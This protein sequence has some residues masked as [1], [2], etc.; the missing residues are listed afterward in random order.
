MNILPSDPHLR[1]C[2]RFLGEK[3]HNWIAASQ[4]LRTP[5]AAEVSKERQRCPGQGDGDGEGEVCDQEKLGGR[6]GELEGDCS[7]S[8]ALGSDSEAKKRGD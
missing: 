1:L 4:G 8:E 3:R 5:G 2:R 7:D 6:E